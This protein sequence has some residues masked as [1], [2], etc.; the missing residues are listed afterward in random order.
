MTSRRIPQVT[1]ETKASEEVEVQI[2]EVETRLGRCERSSGGQAAI[3]TSS[4]VVQ[5]S[6]WNK[7][8]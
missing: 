6:S 5:K 7:N 4:F 1:K 3:I 8:E 2:Q